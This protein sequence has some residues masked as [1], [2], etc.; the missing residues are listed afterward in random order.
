LHLPRQR[1]SGQCEDCQ[2]PSSRERIRVAKGTS[3]VECSYSS[4]MNNVCLRH[5]GSS[6]KARPSQLS[7]SG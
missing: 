4:L 5:T 1:F 7:N 3:R 2:F 6:A